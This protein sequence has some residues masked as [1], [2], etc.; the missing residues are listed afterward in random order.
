MVAGY[1][2]HDTLDMLLN[3]CSWRTLELFFHHVVVLTGILTS[4][5]GHRYLG[6]VVFGL[7]I[8]LNSVTL[9]VRSLMNHLRVSRA[10]TIYQTLSG[11][12]LVTMLVFRLAP[13]LY[14]T[15][16]LAVNILSMPWYF[17]IACFFVIVSLLITNLVLAYRVLHADGY[18]GSNGSEDVS[19]QQSL[20]HNIVVKEA[21]DDDNDQQS[22]IIA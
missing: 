2:C 17:V 18:I 22:A 19:N 7:L 14:M 12:N 1:M 16:W 21:D 3:E 5:I 10:S 20:N 11:F 8:E 13:S 15:G 9:H 6:V 4:L